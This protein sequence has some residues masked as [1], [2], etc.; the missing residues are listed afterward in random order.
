MSIVLVVLWKAGVTD[1]G[2]RNQVLNSTSIM[3]RISWSQSETSLS[4]DLCCIQFQLMH[5]ILHRQELIFNTAWNCDLELSRCNYVLYKIGTMGVVLFTFQL[6]AW[7]AGY[8][9]C[10]IKTSVF[11]NFRFDEIF[12]SFLN[13]KNIM[14]KW[15]SSNKLNQ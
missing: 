3:I 14:Q 11:N 5:K 7:S 4:Y 6:P 12:S 8:F 9:P 2:A 10:K 13:W 1:K 15:Y